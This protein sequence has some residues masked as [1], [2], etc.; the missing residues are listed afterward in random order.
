MKSKTKF[1]PQ[2][3]Q[4]FFIDH[5]EK[6]VLGLVAVLF[7]FFAYQSFTLTFYQK[8]DKT[9]DMLKTAISSAS[10][11]ITSGP[12]SDKLAKVTKFPPYADLING[13]REPV[14]VDKY[15]MPPRCNFKP[16][17]PRPVRDAPEV[18]AVENPRA[19][20][21][22]GAFLKQQGETIGQRWIVVTG[23]VPYGKQ[24]AE[25]RKQYQG[26]AYESDTDVPKYNGFI[27]QRAE[28]PP[29]FKGEPDWKKSVTV[30][31]PLPIAG[32]WRQVR[33]LGGNWQGSRRQ[34]I[35]RRTP[36]VAVAAAGRG[37]LGRGSR[38]PAANQVAQPR[39]PGRRRRPTQRSTDAFAGWRGRRPGPTRPRWYPSRGLRPQ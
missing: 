32:D 10:A 38:P 7:V 13:A 39:R 27:V 29:G 22:R 6:F 15:P 37:S 30:S 17:A 16:I 12:P 20:P 19:V 18:F 28:V 35:C 4:Q 31:C 24:L 23:L 21:G 11:K 34:G 3:I 25:Y 33:Q 9:P 26:A 8:Y 14:I 36:H 1:D 5:T 2:V